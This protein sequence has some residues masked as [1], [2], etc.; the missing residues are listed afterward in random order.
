MKF[1]SILLIFLFPFFQTTN[2]VVEWVTVTEFDFGDIEKEEESTY[3]FQFK[4]ITDA[5]I[6]IDNV[7]PD[8]GC[9]APEWGSEPIEPDSIGTIQV[10]F[11]ARKKG[12][13]YKKVKVF[14][15]GQKKAE[16]LY[17]EGFVN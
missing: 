7:R 14:F 4:N 11:D 16:R 1:F 5:P 6:V 2:K 17:L 10:T 13:F 8:C 12:Y 15:S 9:T 3:H